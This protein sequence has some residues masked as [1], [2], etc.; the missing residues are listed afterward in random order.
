MIKAIADKILKDTNLVSTLSKYGE[1]EI[2][3]SY[4]YDLMVAP[5]IDIIVTTSDPKES[6]FAALKDLINQRLFQ[7]YQYG[8]FVKFPKKNRPNGYIVVLILEIEDIKWEI[9]IWFLTEKSEKAK[10]IDYLMENLNEDSR[11]TIL[12]MKE[13][14]ETRGINKKDISSTEIYEAVLLQNVTSLDQIK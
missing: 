1:V 12:K 4:K 5:D 13:D 11:K 10:E 6:S 8:D 3:G 7:K 2:T 9:E 14:K